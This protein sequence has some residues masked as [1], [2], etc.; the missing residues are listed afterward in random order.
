MR[1]RGGLV[2]K[3]ANGVTSTLG[4]ANN[5]DTTVNKWVCEVGGGVSGH[6][7]TCILGW[8]GGRTDIF[9]KCDLQ[10]N[11]GSHGNKLDI[12]ANIFVFT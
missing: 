3:D 10:F 9:I 7:P 8:G 4:Q 1:P 11:V 2:A 5:T 12:T 6:L